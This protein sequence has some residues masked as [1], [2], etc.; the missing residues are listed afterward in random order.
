MLGVP[1]VL[2]SVGDVGRRLPEVPR[3]VCWISGA[4][5]RY[6]DRSALAA[7]RCVPHAVWVDTWFAGEEDFRIRYDLPPSTLAPNI[8][9][10]ILASS[11]KVVFTIS[12]RAS[13]DF[14]Q[15]WVEAGADLVSLPLA[16][17]SRRYTSEPTYRPEFDGIRLA[18]VGGYWPYKARQLDR[19]LRAYQDELTVFGYSPWPY[20]GYAGQLAPECESSLY[21]QALVSPCIN[22]PHVE[23]MGVDLNERVFK[24]LGS[25]GVAVT[26]AVPVYR[27]WFADDELLVPR[28]V[29]EFHELVTMLLADE[30][31]RERLAQAGARAVSERHTY[32]HR[33]ATL[34]QLLGMGSEYAVCS[35]PAEPGPPYRG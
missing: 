4:D 3:P 6:L 14:Y 27:E 17:D 10:R 1:Y 9:A 34:S 21:H 29:T 11:P 33:A 22:E 35:S 32:A 30:H 24:V 31:A 19:Y 23:L 5:Y 8:R 12:P 15:G 2:M 28:S 13:F 16:C 7:L 25:A 26:D 18:F 20:P